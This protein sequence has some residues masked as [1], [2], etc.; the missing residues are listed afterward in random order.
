MKF[1]LSEWGS[2]SEILGGIAIV[3]SLAILIVEVRENTAALER[4]MAHDRMQSVSRDMIQ[5]Q[6]LPKI[7]HKI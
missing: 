5:T 4:Q 2:I 7:L 6:E 1:S 3:I